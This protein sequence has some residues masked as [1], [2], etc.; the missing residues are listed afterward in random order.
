MLVIGIVQW[1]RQV[2]LL[3][4]VFRD[5]DSEIAYEPWDSNHH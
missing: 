1:N 4:F 2:I 3:F 5:Y